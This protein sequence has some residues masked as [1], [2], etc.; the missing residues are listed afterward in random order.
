MLQIRIAGFFQDE[1]KGGVFLICNN[2][3]QGWCECDACW[4]LD[5]A[6]EREKGFVSTRFYS[7]LNDVARRVHDAHPAARLWAFAYQNFQH[8]PT[9]TRP[10]PRLSINMCLHGRCYRH[11]LGDESCAANGKHRDFLQGWLKLGNKVMAR[12][13]YSCFVDQRGLPDAIVYLPL[14]KLVADDIRYLHRIGVRGW[15][16]EVPP[17]NAR[18]TERFAKRGITESW[19]ARFPLYYV[20]AKLTWDPHQDVDALL[21]DMNEKLYGPAAPAMAKYRA[22]LTE[23]WHETNGHFIYGGSYVAMGRSLARPGAQEKLLSYLTEAEAAAANSPAILA[24]V[25]LDREYFDLAWQRTY[26]QFQ[27]MARGD[28]HAQK[29]DGEVRIDGVLDEPAWQRAEYVTGFMRSGTERAER[30]TYVRLLYD[31][32]HLYVAAEA[33][34]PH[35]DRLRANYLTRDSKVWSDD[36]I[37][38]FIDPQG[39]GERYCHLAMNPSGALYD[40][41]CDVS[42][43]FNARFNADCKVAAS[44]LTDRWVV[45][46][47]LRASSMGAAIRDMGQWKM[48][49]GRSRKAAGAR[50]HSTWFDGAYHQPASFRTVVFGRQAIIQNGGFEDLVELNTDA[51]LKRHGRGWTFT[52]SPPRVPRSWFLHEQHKGTATVVADAHSG[53]WAWQVTDGWFHQR[54]SLRL[55]NDRPLRIEF[56]AKG[57][58]KVRVAAY[59]YADVD[60]RARFVRTEIIGSV[61]ASSDWGRH[62]LIY[63]AATPKTPIA[64]LAFWVAGSVALDDVLVRQEEA[65]N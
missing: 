57:R 11:S 38:I 9:G 31:A 12:E 10:D 25:R 42:A 61:A 2:D 28:V 62:E 47:R 45:E 41:E 29:R 14:E 34:E 13:Y 63:S 52:D 55:S 27:A 50:E 20:A 17:M 40:A 22:L 37:E 36:A 35:T 3:G 46:L 49:I 21:S 26:R 60:G 58:G 44:A 54:M 43:P 16:D 56:W 19:R 7:F 64:S 53:E 39:T 24:R 15:H 59:L 18:F 4:A 33:V 65:R 32:D 51:L 30:Q 5:P 8:P 1:P 48:N 6:W 23:C